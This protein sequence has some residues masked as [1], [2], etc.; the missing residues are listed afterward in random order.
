MNTHMMPLASQ[1]KTQIKQLLMLSLLVISMSGAF[2]QNMSIN[3]NGAAPDSSA[4]LDISSTS[5]G[6]LFP[7]M[8]LTQ[9]NAISSPAH[10]LMIYQTDNAEGLWVYDTASTD[11]V[12]VLM[13]TDTAALG[14]AGVLAS[15]ND[16][17]NDSILNLGVLGIGTTTPSKV[18]HVRHASSDGI[19]TDR[20]TTAIYSGHTWLDDGTER[21][22]IGQEPSSNDLIIRA[23]GVD[24]LVEI[25]TFGNVGI[26]TSTPLEALQIDSFLVMDAAGANGVR[27]YGYNLYSDGSTYKYVNDG[28]ASAYASGDDF[29]GLFYWPLG[30]AGGNVPNDASSLIR[31]EDST[32]TFNTLASDSNFDMSGH[33]MVDSLTVGNYNFPIQDGVLNQ[34]L[35]TDGSGNVTWETPNSASDEISDA[36]N[37]T[38]VTTENTTDDDLVQMFIEGSLVYTIDHGHIFISNVGNNTFLGGTAGAN[39]L[40]DGASNN[41]FIGDA[42]GTSNTSGSNNTAMGVDALRSSTTGTDNATAI[43]YQ[44]LRNS[45]GG[46]NNTAIG[47]QSML[48][49]TGSGYQNTAVG[50]LSLAANTSGYQNTSIGMQSLL[51]NTTGIGNVALGYQAGSTSSVGNFNIFIGHQAGA[52][53]TGSEKLY[54]ENSSST[55]PLIYGDFANDTVKINGTLGILDAFHFPST[56]GSAD[57]VLTTDGSGNVTWEDVPGDTLSFVQDTDGNTKIQT[58]KFTNEDVIRFDLGGT[59]VLRL[60]D[61]G[62]MQVSNA[63]SGLFIGSSAGS[64]I[65]TGSQNTF[66]GYEAGAN[67][68]NSSSSTY[69]GYR[70]GYTSN[71]ASN[72]AIGALSGDALTSGT[73]NTF[74][75]TQSGSGTNTGAYNVFLG[76]NAGRINST[77]NQNVYIGGLAGD[78]NNGSD[79]I[80]IGDSAGYSVTGVSDR[81]IIDNSD[82][83]TPLIYGDFAKD[84]LVVNASLTIHRPSV[85][86]PISITQGVFVAG[87]SAMELNT[88]DGNG[89]LATR[90]MME[91]GT[92]T[93]IEFYTGNAGSEVEMLHMEGSTNRIGI[94]LSNPA[95]KLDVN[96]TFSAN[97]VNVNDA[98]TFPTA[99]G[100]DG[101][102][103]Q[104]DGSGSL[105]WVNP[106]FT[107]LA[108]ADNDTKIQV[109]ESTDED[110]IRFDVAG[111]QA[112]LINN[113]GRFAFGINSP[114]ADFHFAGDSLLI[115]SST[116]NGSRLILEG[117]RNNGGSGGHIGEIVFL[118]SDDNSSSSQYDAARIESRNGGNS[119]DGD[120]R[121]YTTSNLTSAEAMIIDIDGSVGV[122]TSSP[123]AMFHVNG[124]AL[125]ATGGRFGIRSSVTDGGNGSTT[126]YGIHS[127]PSSGGGGSNTYYGLYSNTNVTSGGSSSI[128]L[129]SYGATYAA[130][131]EG[132]NVGIGTDSPTEL[133]HL[134]GGDMLLDRGGS[135]SVTRTITL[136]GAAP[137][138]SS[139]FGKI[140]FYGYDNTSGS[141]EYEGAAITAHNLG[142]VN[143]GNLDFW[144]FDG[145]NLNSWLRITRNGGV[146]VDPNNNG[147]AS[148]SVN[149]TA[150]VSDDIT[151]GSDM[152]IDDAGYYYLGGQNTNGSWRI[153]RS[154]N[155]LIF[156]RRES[157]SWVTK[158]SIVP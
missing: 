66:I 116:F 130:I 33:L 78:Q 134:D 59:E 9:R 147:G 62:R 26:G 75:G 152:E 40:M 136:K 61:N 51:S 129:Y 118:N 125:S 70:A 30:T 126:I 2:A 63:V 146:Q 42:A 145:T 4:M 154:G 135:S 148:L 119:D 144:T 98:F 155:N 54:I 17:A 74:L 19:T 79:N 84:S 77:G 94:G 140:S 158:T 101:Q 86:N 3:A 64:S 99:D 72:T 56:D 22:F 10:G 49:N 48:Q 44:A 127:E 25:D 52:S 21:W 80:F 46:V 58:E 41:T 107:T 23:N 27:F 117:Q 43:G 137:L 50:V 36:D 37:D 132:G 91:S 105:S 14:L 35:T 5:Q 12:K 8:T 142:S 97:S 89:T 151:G 103:M 73:N 34:V 143:Y 16:A 39:D 67:A 20:A 115:Q 96:G 128:G 29:T 24:N 55:T 93:D 95:Y 11:W 150:S 123:E 106:S 87:G 15:D 38:R 100:S 149:G 121:F 76:K 138:G 114:E 124:P 69:L 71:G 92:N 13:A 108:D 102:V 112:M 139:V 88:I 18:L 157:G 65:S 57:Q 153:G 85:A 113:S 90:L 31:M 60:H 6:V 131:F 68:S 120:L 1:L 32:I 156:Q 122:G 109:E 28:P 45:T 133:L 83:A 47:Y 111:S 7:R 104:T 53:E 110:V 141:F 81:L 82:N